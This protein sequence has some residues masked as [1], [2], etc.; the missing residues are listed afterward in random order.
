[1]FATLLSSRSYEREWF[2]P[3]ILCDD[4]FTEETPIPC[5]LNKEEHIKFIFTEEEIRTFKRNGMMSVIRNT[6]PSTL[7]Y[8]R[9]ECLV[10][11]IE[12]P[13]R[14]GELNHMAYAEMTGRSNLRIPETDTYRI[15]IAVG[16]ILVQE[17]IQ[18]V[19]DSGGQLYS[20]GKARTFRSYIA[21]TYK[22]MAMYSPQ[23]NGVPPEGEN[24]DFEK[25]TDYFEPILTGY[26]II[27]GFGIPVISY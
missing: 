4:N 2:E 9:G 12:M 26:H 5:F 1:M 13:M 19:E 17:M 27:H 22:C 6:P 8:F 21:P 16:Y 11:T 18:E 3:D 14:K 24:N 20:D 10:S 25:M 15:P 7:G 23:W